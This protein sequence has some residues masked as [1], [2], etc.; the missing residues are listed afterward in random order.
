MAICTLSKIIRRSAS[1]A[2]LGTSVP[3]AREFTRV[4][5]RLTF[6]PIQIPQRRAA[7][8]GEQ[9]CSLVL[10]TP[11]FP[12]RRNSHSQ[13]PLSGAGWKPAGLSCRKP[14]RLQATFWQFPSRETEAQR[15]GH[16][17]PAFCGQQGEVTQPRLDPRGPNSLLGFRCYFSTGEK[18]LQ[19]LG[20]GM[21]R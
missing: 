1:I 2:T 5:A 11:P 3:W 4:E 7:G 20:E 8:A 21:R 9:P 14:H 6:S 17:W 16:P 13:S 15:S 10:I 19:G 18:I 12:G